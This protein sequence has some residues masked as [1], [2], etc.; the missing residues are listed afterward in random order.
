MNL[1]HESDMENNQ[2][3]CSYKTT[4]QIIEAWKTSL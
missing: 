3:G 2:N 4:Q 1:E